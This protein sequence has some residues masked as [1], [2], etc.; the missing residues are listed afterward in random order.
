[1]K[2]N[3]IAEMLKFQKANLT[4]FFQSLL[5]RLE[6]LKPHKLNTFSTAAD[7]TGQI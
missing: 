4:K 6:V 3:E 1:M 7:E 2:K 5:R